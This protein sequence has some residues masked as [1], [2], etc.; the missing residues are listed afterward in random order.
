[1]A[2]KQ[3]KTV[4][5]ALPAKKKEETIAAPAVEEVAP[6]AAKKKRITLA[7]EGIV[8]AEEAAAKKAARKE[9]KTAPKKTKEEAVAELKKKVEEVKK[10]AEAK[11]K[12]PVKKIT[13]EGEDAESD[14]EDDVSVD[15]EFSD[16]EDGNVKIPAKKENKK[17]KAEKKKQ[18]HVVL[19]LRHL[20]K[21][22][23]EP[24]L[25][26][27]FSQFN[28]N[29]VSAFCMRSKRNHQSLG[30]AFVQF[31]DL[32][33]L[34]TVIDECHGMLL[35][36]R[37]VRA[38][39]VR[40]NRALPSK[41]AVIARMNRAHN[42]EARG[43]KLNR[44]DLLKKQKADASE[45]IRKVVGYLIKYSRTESEQNKRLK[46]LGIEYAFD[47]FKSQLD[48]VHKSHFMKK[49]ECKALVEKK[50]AEKKEE[51]KKKK[52]NNKKK[53]AGKKAVKA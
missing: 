12:K 33:V 35:G 8:M 43:V 23:E 14:N 4:K 25:I 16:D 20:P 21:E 37:T 45:D 50:K 11:K 3:Q 10:A 26:R 6:P 48:Q 29:V 32:S 38:R 1:M 17:K 49:A 51:A 24:Q 31:D 52:L 9:A 19:Q 2:P 27:F 47:G 39:R 18:S 46:D 22:F 34:P 36:G 44:F 5:K 30:T 53:F 41:K 15:L 42:I 13:I 28:A 40:I 7:P